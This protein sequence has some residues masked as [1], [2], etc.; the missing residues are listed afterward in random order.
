[1]GDLRLFL[2][3][4]IPDDLRLKIAGIQDEL[5]PNARQVKW[6]EPENL[7]LTLKF[8][9][10]TDA[11][12]VGGLAACAEAV[13]A[14]IAPMELVL[15]GLGAFPNAR[16]PHTVWI[17]LQAGQ[18]PLAELAEALEEA[19]ARECGVPRE[20]RRFGGHL[21]IGRVKSPEPQP[22]LTTALAEGGDRA[23]GGYRLDAFDL[24]QSELRPTGPLYTLLHRFALTA[25]PP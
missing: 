18:E 8:L 9:G 4:P 13:A 22:R 2:A 19:L 14:R 10:A 11:E 25:T 16:R 20:E 15:A 1:M 17:G 23:I 6:V 24:Y 3:A 5:R 7:H 12:Q 21:T